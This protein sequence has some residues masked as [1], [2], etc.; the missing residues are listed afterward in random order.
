MIFYHYK[1]SKANSLEVNTRRKINSLAP[2]DSLKKSIEFI[3]ALIIFLLQTFSS[4]LSKSFYFVAL[5]YLDF[6]FSLTLFLFLFLMG[7]LN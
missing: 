7:K 2:V 3:L 6:S 4:S 1:K 5:F